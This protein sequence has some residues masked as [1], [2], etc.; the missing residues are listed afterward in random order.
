MSE[1]EEL[2]QPVAADAVA[3]PDLAYDPKRQE[4]EAAFEA[5]RL[6][7]RGEGEA[8]DWSPV[9][10]SIKE[11]SR[12]TK[13]ASLAVFLARAG[14]RAQRLAEVELGCSFLAA[15]FETWWEQIHPSLGEYGFQG[16]KG[17]CE[18]LVSIGDFL[19][20]LRRVVLVSHDRLGQFTAEQIETFANQGD[21]AENIGM[22]RAALA[23][24]DPSEIAASIKTLEDIR[25]AVSR[26]DAVLTAKAEGDTG[27]NFTPTY[28]AIDSI[29]KALVTVTGIG[30]PMDAATENPAEASSSGGNG[31]GGGPVESRADVIR[32]LESIIAYYSKH[33]PGSPIPLV[34]DRAKGWVNMDF[35]SILN[36]INPSSAEDAKRVLSPKAA[37]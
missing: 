1:L 29:H 14:A 37:E 28:E 23:E 35:L 25:S 22:F 8:V 33:E 17:A 3:G 27:T 16:R 15:M 24:I 11:Q 30:V 4:I 34:L 9:I 21:S 20:P 6:A 36:D 19:G 13:D 12:L 18:S 32:A 26:V 7:D 2:M 10:K 31:G 5:A